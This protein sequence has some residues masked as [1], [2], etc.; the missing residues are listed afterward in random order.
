[1]I[2]GAFTDYVRVDNLTTGQTLASATLA[3]TAGTLAAG[4]TSATRQYTFTLPAGSAGAG[5][6]KVTVTTD[7]FDNVFEYSTSHAAAEANNTTS[8]TVTANVAPQPDLV[9][10]S[11]TPTATAATF[12]SSLGVS[13]QVLNAGTLQAVGPWND[14]IYL[15]PHATFD[16]SAVA[17]AT[18]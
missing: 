5:Q 18:L 1:D 7:Y 14:T 12:G 9:V 11:V 6:I 8:T 4:G 13:W 3:Y 15:S 2:T 16:G 10:T 17:L